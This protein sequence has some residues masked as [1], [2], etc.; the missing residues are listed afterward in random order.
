M[1]DSGRIIDTPFLDIKY[2]PYAVKPIRPK[3]GFPQGASLGPWPPEHL[4]PLY[5]VRNED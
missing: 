4:K 2:K 3:T 1:A 5:P